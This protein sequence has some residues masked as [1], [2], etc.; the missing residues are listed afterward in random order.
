MA[1]DWYPSQEG[2]IVDGLTINCIAEDAI[3]EGS[4]VLWGTSTAGQI[5]VGPATA[6]GDGF[7]VAV[8]AAAAAGDPVPVMV[9]GVYKMTHSDGSAFPEQGEICMNSTTIYVCSVED[10]GVTATSLKMYAGNSYILGMYLQTTTATSDEVL[11]LVGRT[12]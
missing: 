6:L 1:T 5:T 2:R 4:A 7:G 11:I 3:V 12:T 10:I 9:L 8:K